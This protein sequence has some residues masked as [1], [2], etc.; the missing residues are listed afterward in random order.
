MNWTRRDFIKA[1]AL[2]AAGLA[3]NRVSQGQVRRPA[4][5]KDTKLIF[6]FQR[7]GNDGVNTVIPYG[8]P[9]YSRTNRPTLF[10]PQASALD[11]GN[12]F[13]GLHPRMAPMMEIFNQSQLN[14]T[15]G[16]G[17]L[18]VIHRVGYAR[19]SQSHFTSQQYWENGLP[20]D[21]SFEEGMI[22][23]AIANTMNPTTNRMAGAA[24]SGS[25]LVALKGPIALPT[26]QNPDAYRFTGGD[27][28]VQKFIGHLPS[29]PQG[30]DGAGLLGAYGGTRD[31]PTK[32]YRD[33]VYNTG[34][35]LTD[36]MNSVQ[37]AV[38]QGP[39]EP[40][41]GATYP[42]GSF[43]DKLQRAAM[44]LKRTPVRVLGLNIG[45]WDTHT[46]QGQINGKHGN[47]LAQVAQGF[48]ALYRDLEDQW[49]QL[50]IVT[51][52][53]FG[54]TS[55]ENGSKGTDHAQACVMFAAGGPVQGG[56]YNCDSTTWAPGDLFSSKDRYILRKTDYRAIFAE[57]FTRHLGTPY[58]QLDHIIPGYDQAVLEEPEDFAFLNFL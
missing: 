9:Q 13:A 6:I 26:I 42:T 17:N 2:G 50:L 31:Y 35:A 57:I 12:D 46:N 22:Y 29:A 51:M 1:G 21:S 45:G 23:R 15:D 32:P 8:D 41:G 4:A 19:Q 5:P 3:L 7:G 14:G 36:S 20:G 18:A 53:E 30:T 48:Q 49:D 52:T 16:P 38:A 44:L 27:A 24:L 54:R 56:V 33:L 28:K 43:G 10:I 39:Y 11:L 47:L 34:L 55:K 40:T 25:Q 58:P 37:A